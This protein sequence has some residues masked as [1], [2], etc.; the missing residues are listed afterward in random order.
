[1]S[2][3]CLCF[4][5]NLWPGRKPQSFPQGQYC[6]LPLLTQS[7]AIP[8]WEKKNV[9]FECSSRIFKVRRNHIRKQAEKSSM[10]VTDTEKEH[11]ELPLCLLHQADGGSQQTASW[12]S[13]QVQEGLSYQERKGDFQSYWK[14]LKRSAWVTNTCSRVWDMS[15]G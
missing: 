2:V 15:R 11:P 8:K 10:V 3:E 5:L 9:A 1:M 13:L 14:Q 12:G 7:R 4:T 6:F